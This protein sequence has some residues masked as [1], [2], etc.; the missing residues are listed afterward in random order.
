MADETA[1]AVAASPEKA[2]PPKKSKLVPLL[3]IVVIVLLLGGGGAGWFLL[4][5]GAKPAPEA[6]AAPEPATP[7][8]TMH[9]DGFTVNLA[10]AESNDFLRITIDLGLGHAPAT[11]KS[12]SG[13]FPTSRVRDAIL[14][15]LTAAKAD[16]LL[17]PE[18][19]AKLKE[20]LIQ[21]LRENVPEIDVRDVYFTEFLV[22]K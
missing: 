10:D 18:G 9:L 5:R 19:K 14:P 1:V 4:H 11:D 22:Q 6:A 3:L 12:G 20:D 17:T 2:A 16:V 8:Y 7:K 21:T 13:D 15:V